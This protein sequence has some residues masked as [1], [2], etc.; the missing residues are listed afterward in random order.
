ME[1]LE[2]T[3]LCVDNTPKTLCILAWI[4]RL[5]CRIRSASFSRNLMLPAHGSKNFIGR[6]GLSFGDFIQAPF[7]AHC[8][9]NVFTF[10]PPLLDEDIIPLFPKVALNYYLVGLCVILRSSVVLVAGL[11]NGRVA[12]SK[13]TVLEYANGNKELSCRRCISANSPGAKCSPYVRLPT[14]QL[15]YDSSLLGSWPDYR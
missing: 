6:F 3:L 15:H 5:R 7:Y 11:V 1:G 14:G 8:G 9:L 10:H 12:G 2:K 13:V 4:Y